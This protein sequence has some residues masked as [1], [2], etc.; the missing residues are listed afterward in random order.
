MAVSTVGRGINDRIIDFKEGCAAS[1]DVNK[2]RSDWDGRV[3]REENLSMKGNAASS[4]D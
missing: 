2:G 4:T 3:A 1:N